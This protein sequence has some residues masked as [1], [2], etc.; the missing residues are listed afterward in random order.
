MESLEITKD[1]LNLNKLL[2]Q[3]CIIK[4]LGLYYFH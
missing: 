1:E 3:R 4:G 2:F